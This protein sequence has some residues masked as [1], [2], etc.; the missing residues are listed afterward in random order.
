MQ[1]RSEFLKNLAQ[2][3]K[4]SGKAFFVLSVRTGRKAVVDNQCVACG[5]GLFC[6]R[7][8]RGELRSIR[9]RQGAREIGRSE[10][11]SAGRS[12]QH[13]SRRRVRLLQASRR[14]A[15][16]G[17]EE[18]QDLAMVHRQNARVEFCQRWCHCDFQAPVDGSRQKRQQLFR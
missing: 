9:C 16:K 11:R 12:V 14:A 3:Y 5:G 8:Y 6:V 18:G 10:T 1:F 7:E 13:D 4:T 15:A 2:I 17:V